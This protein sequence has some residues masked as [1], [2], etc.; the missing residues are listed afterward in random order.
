[1]LRS[2]QKLVRDTGPKQL[3]STTRARTLGALL[4]ER[5]DVLSR[6][7]AQQYAA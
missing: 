1:M 4:K 6:V 3:E 7:Y 5:T 2:S